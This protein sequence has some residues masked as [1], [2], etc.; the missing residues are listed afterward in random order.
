MCMSDTEI[1]EEIDFGVDSP[2]EPNT[3][4]ENGVEGTNNPWVNDTQSNWKAMQNS[5]KA[6]LDEKDSQ[7]SEKDKTIAELRTQL[8]HWGKDTVPATEATDTSVNANAI[9]E[10]TF[11]MNNPEAKEQLEAIRK[12]K[13]THNLPYDV[14][15]QLTKANLSESTS[16]NDI[17]LNTN[18]IPTRKKIEDI[19]D[20]T[21]RLT[22]ELKLAR[23]NPSAYAAYRAKDWL[24]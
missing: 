1:S 7:L 18:Y 12:T 17:S 9:E 22:A 5:W 20:P 15:Y 11:L 8:E 19:L 4:S 23:E 2:D 10:L 21:E 13:S 14:A 24:R 3:G 16:S 6:K